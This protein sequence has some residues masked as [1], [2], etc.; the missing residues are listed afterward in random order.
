EEADI[1]HRPWSGGRED[2]KKR[3]TQT[4]PPPGCFGHPR[5]GGGE[6]RDL[7]RVA[8][9]AGAVAR[10]V[11]ATRACLGAAHRVALRFGRACSGH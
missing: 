2:L 9:P 5:R 6:G 10:E 8:A 3:Q 1:R 11:R 4:P 7:A